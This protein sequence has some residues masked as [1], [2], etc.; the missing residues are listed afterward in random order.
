MKKVLIVASE[1]SSLLAQAM[2]HVLADK[3]R[4]VVICSHKQ[5]LT[6]FI[7]EEPNT[8]I[9]LDYYEGLNDGQLVGERTFNDLKAAATDEKIIRCGLDSYGHADYLKLP[10]DIE[11]LKILLGK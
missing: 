4:K 3:K 10:C 6:S 8:V 11:E 7:E 2:Q 5:A 1:M 9:V